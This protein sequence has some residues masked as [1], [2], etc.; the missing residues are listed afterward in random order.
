MVIF[1]VPLRLLSGTMVQLL[2]PG[3]THV[4]FT[5]Q[6]RGLQTSQ[7]ILTSREL[8]RKIDSVQSFKQ[9]AH[10]IA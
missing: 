3:V 7:H 2:N 9:T 6:V 5:A 10:V 4:Y 8:V 1:V